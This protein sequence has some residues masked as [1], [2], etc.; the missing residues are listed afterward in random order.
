MRVEMLVQ[1]ILPMVLHHPL[2]QNRPAAA[3]DSRNPLR[4]QRHILH[5]HARV[6]RHVIHA[7]LGLLF[8]HLEHHVDVEIFHAPH[9]RQR[10]IYRYRSDRHR[11]V[12]DDGFANLRDVA[13]RRKI[14]HRIGAELHRVP[15]L[16]QLFRRYSM[17]SPNCRYSR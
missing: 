9:A 5:Q 2:G 4:R 13:A 10:F 7:L 14:H 15:Q 1:Q 6:D 8:N 16:F 17:S 12:R 11:R 3:H